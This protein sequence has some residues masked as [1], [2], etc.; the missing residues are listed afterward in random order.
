MTRL[1]KFEKQMLHRA[2]Q[3]VMAGEWPWEGDG[4]DRDTKKEA[5]EAAALESAAAKLASSVN[6][7]D[8][9]E[10]RKP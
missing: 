8:G 7:H 5:R 6:S 9:A 1:T 2:A 3:F 10:V 4:S